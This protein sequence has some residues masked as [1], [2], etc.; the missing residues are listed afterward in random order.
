MSSITIKTSMKRLEARASSGAPQIMGAPSRWRRATFC[1]RPSLTKKKGLCQAIS[2]RPYG[3]SS[4]PWA[5]WSW[6]PAARSYPEPSTVRV[7]GNDY[8]GHERSF[9]GMK[10]VPAP[11]VHRWLSRQNAA[12]LFTTAI[13]E[14]EILAGAALLPESRRKRDLEAAARNILALFSGRILPFDSAAA[15][16]YAEIVAARQRGRAAH[17]GL[18]RSNR[19]RCPHAR[20]R[21]GNARQLRFRADG[22][23][24]RQSVDSVT[25]IGRRAALPA[26]AFSRM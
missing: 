25:G 20:I 18:R 2:R 14:A 3:Q 24:D 21:G 22:C 17:R 7:A 5:A 10:P 13:C 23:G 8:F 1:V 9:G 11:E 16:H 19:K 12:E 6:T 26:P 15:S 4:S